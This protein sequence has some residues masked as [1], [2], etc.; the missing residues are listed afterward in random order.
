M[1]DTGDLA[2]QLGADAA[3]NEQLMGASFLA[4]NGGKK[5]VTVN[6]KSAD[7]KAVLRR[8][9]KTADVLVENFRPGVMK[10]L[11]L[12]YEDLQKENPALIYC[13]ISGF[14]QDGPMKD[15]P[16]YDQIIQGLSGMMSI[17][18]DEQLCAAARWLSSGRHDWGHYRRVGD[19]ECFGTT[20]EHRR[21]CVHR[22]LDVGLCTRDDGMGRFQLFDRRP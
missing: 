10:R 8:L 16:A 20:S 14:G 15:A 19:H 4:Q 1:P 5:S 6:L 3:L 17:T 9:V 2:R 13:A 7:G 22:R 21:G 12:G 18:G 11:G